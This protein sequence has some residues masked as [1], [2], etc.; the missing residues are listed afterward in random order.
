MKSPGSLFCYIRP[1]TRLAPSLFR[2]EKNGKGKGKGMDLLQVYLFWGTREG[3]NK[4]RKKEEGRNFFLPSS[5]FLFFLF[6]IYFFLLS[7]P[8]KDRLV[9]SPGRG[10]LYQADL[11][12][13]TKS[14]R[15][16]TDDE[17]DLGQVYP[18]TGVS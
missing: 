13:M 12:Q 14:G 2:Q 6:F 5:F 9:A 1:S 4:K 8:K 16:I 3:K 15:L 18:S 17:I 10:S 7:F 11:L